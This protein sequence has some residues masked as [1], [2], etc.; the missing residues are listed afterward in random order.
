MLSKAGKEILLKSVV[1]SILM[2]VMR[3][4]LL[5]LSLY[6]ELECMMNSFWWGKN[7]ASSR[8]I[9]WMSW[10]KLCTHKAA[11]GTGF[12]KLHEFNLAML[13]K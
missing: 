6:N 12:R 5:P 1:Q 3:V 7:D 9:N 10:N 4:F 13:G 8:G 2:Y 11:G